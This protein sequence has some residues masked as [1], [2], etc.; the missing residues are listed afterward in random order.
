MAIAAQACLLLLGEARP[1]AVFPGLRQVLLYPGS[2][3]VER[4]L[5]QPGGVQQLQRQALAGESWQHGQV[6]LS[7]P[8]V[9]AGAADPHD[10]ENLV[11]HE[12][13]HQVDQDKGAADGRPWRPGRAARQR[14][15]AVMGAAF[16]ALQHQ[17]C[18]LLG[19]YAATAPAEFLAV[20]TERFFE[21]PDELAATWP[22]VYG[23]LQRLYRVDPR[24]WG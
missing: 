18:D 3:V 10:G 1:A 23:E 20:A 16:T 15:D 21:R 2:F 7:W 6:V 8:D 14:W 11:L 5:H 17:P 22:Q 4:P 19:A 24:D 13:A 9:V 12:F